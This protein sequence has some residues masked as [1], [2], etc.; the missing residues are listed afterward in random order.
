MRVSVR[1]N[2]SDLTIKVEFEPSEPPPW[3]QEILVAACRDAGKEKCGSPMRR[4]C[5]I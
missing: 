2:D 1:Q 5:G 4:T 3:N